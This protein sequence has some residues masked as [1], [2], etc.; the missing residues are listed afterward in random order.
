LHSTCIRCYKHLGDVKVYEEATPE[1]GRLGQDDCE[2]QAS[3]GYIAQSQSWGREK[4]EKEGA[5]R[6]KEA[7]GV[8][9]KYGP[10]L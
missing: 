2:F 7:A 9:C 6:E 8:V 3:P 10:T 1:L 5:G 4:R